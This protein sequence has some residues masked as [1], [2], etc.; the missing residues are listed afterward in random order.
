MLVGG[1]VTEPEPADR[2]RDPG[3]RRI[4]ADTRGDGVRQRR[5]VVAVVARAYLAFRYLMYG[6]RVATLAV[7]YSTSSAGGAWV[8]TDFDRRYNQGGD[9]VRAA[10]ALP[11]G[12]RRAR[13]VS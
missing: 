4:P 5:G 8:A 9:W 7:E 13:F 1:G 12:A 6:D 10:A 3:I 2:R 11:P